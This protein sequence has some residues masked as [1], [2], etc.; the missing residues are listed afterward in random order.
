MKICLITV[1]RFKSA[2][3]ER[4]VQHYLKLASKFATPE[5][6]SLSLTKGVPEAQ[7]QDQALLKFLERRGPR[8]HLTIL[9]E[10]GK[11][12][13][14]RELAVKVEKI[15]DASHSEWLIAVGGAHGY[16]EEV[17]ARA[18][19]LWSLSPLTLAHELAT[20]VAAEQLFRV[21]AILNGH[22][23]HNELGR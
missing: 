13:T 22:P 19:W 7:A 11:L 8:A 18:Q 9:D 17:K 14:S 4:L 16:G 12:F 20:A 5:V 10:R 6:V 3:L 1:G 23:Y 15:K 21:L 2:E